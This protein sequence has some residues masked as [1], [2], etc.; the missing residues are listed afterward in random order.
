MNMP[1][2][3]AKI[4]SLKAEVEQLRPINPEQESRIYQKFKLDWNFNSNAI[5]GNKLTQGETEMFLL[6]GLTSKGKPFKDYLD[7]RGHNEAI[8]FSCFLSSTAGASK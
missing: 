1:N 8:D 4:D 6:H 3:F 2:S 5:E 7:I